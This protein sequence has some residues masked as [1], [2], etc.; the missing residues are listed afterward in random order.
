MRGRINRT[1]S[2]KFAFLV[3]IILSVSAMCFIAWKT[4]KVI[5]ELEKNT[6]QI[7][8]RENQMFEEMKTM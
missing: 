5:D 3:I 1:I 8:L 4:F 2:T 7:Q 6:L